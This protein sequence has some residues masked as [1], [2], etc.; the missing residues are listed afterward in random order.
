MKKSFSPMLPLNPFFS[1]SEKQNLAALNIVANVSMG[2]LKGGRW[3]AVFA[4]HQNARREWTATEISLAEETAE[5]TWAAVERARAE[6]ALHQSEEKYRTIFETI[7]EGF[8]IQELL[9]GEDGNVRDIIYREVNEAYTKHTGIRDAKNKKASEL[10]PNIEQHWL[11]Q[12]THVYKTGE[13]VRT[14]GY[15]SDVAR[16]FTLQYSRVG[17]PGSRF[18]S[19]VFNDITERKER[20]GQQAFLL[21]FSDTL[22]TEPTVDAL[23]NRALQLLSDYLKLDRCYI[24]LYQLAEDRGVFPYQVGNERVPPMPAN[25]RLSDFPDAMQVAFH[26]T[27]VINDVAQAEGLA[28]S[29][30]K[31]LGALGLRAFVAATLRRGEALPSWSIVAIS[32]SPRQWSQGE[33]QLLEEVTERTWAA[34]ERA[35][36]EEELR[37]FTE[38][39]EE[40]VRERTA[41]LNKTA[42]ELQ[43]NLA[44]LEQ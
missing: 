14:E 1:I 2:L 22:R 8:T 19:V 12:M 43:S 3:V 11:D 40:I 27:L 5:R 21:S 7:D 31:N 38:Q 28:D 42:G 41:S 17:G 18:I 32:A 37:Q 35:K 4:M 13:P 24:G 30:R 39:L 15:Q 25:V 16:W 26:S 36:A 6:A 33:I 23:A 20:E 29:D 9:I 34:M 44:I 10:F